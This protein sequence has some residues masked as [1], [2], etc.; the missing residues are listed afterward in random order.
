MLFSVRH[1]A[2]LAAITA[3]PTT[4]PAAVVSTEAWWIELDATSLDLSCPH[5]IG[6]PRRISSRLCVKIRACLVPKKFC[7]LNITSNLAAHAW[8][9]KCRRKK[10]LI[11]QLVEKSR[12]ET[13]ESN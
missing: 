3:A 8:S 4:N 2:E 10:K 11:T 6:A 9:T 5:N 12:D 1:S 13:F 7:A